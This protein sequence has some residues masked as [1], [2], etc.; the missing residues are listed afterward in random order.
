MNIDGVT[1]IKS[2]DFFTSSQRVNVTESLMFDTFKVFFGKEFVVSHPSSFF[3]IPH[4]QKI[5]SL[6]TAPQM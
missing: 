4:S 2:F 3:H 1:L 6:F 5:L